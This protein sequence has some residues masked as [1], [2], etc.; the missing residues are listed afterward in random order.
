[1][2]TAVLVVI[3]ALA[4][5]VVW[6]TD[7]VDGD[8]SPATP[9]SEA[10]ERPPT[11]RPVEA[12]G[13]SSAVQTAA[14]PEMAG[15]SPSGRAQN[16]TR[17]PVRRRAARPASRDA[18]GG[19]RIHDSGAVL[20][21]TNPVVE[22]EP[23][24]TEEDDEERGMIYTATA[25]GIRSAVQEAAPKIKECYE[26]WVA[27]NPDLAGRLK[28]TFTISTKT[29][30]DDIARITRAHVVDSELAHGLLEGCV[31]NMME[32]LSFDPPEADEI[33][34]TFPFNFQT[35]PPKDGPDAGP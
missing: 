33:T 11:Q 7:G 13:P 8:D 6:A 27:A 28:V 35:A 23:D 22:E 9:Q 29:D 4:I 26:G 31:L 30:E 2:R 10:S 17:R 32:S 3:I 15:G 18:S 5:L 1:M 34:V 25:E 16:I 20:R 24:P 12:T 21:P 14:R 19:H